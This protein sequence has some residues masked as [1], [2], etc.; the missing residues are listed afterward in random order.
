MSIF[1]IV[2]F[3]TNPYYFP[4]SDKS[5]PSL[6]LPLPHIQISFQNRI[7]K[8]KKTRSVKRKSIRKLKNKKILLFFTTLKINLQI[9]FWLAVED[10]LPILLP[11]F[12]FFFSYHNKKEFKKKRLY[13]QFWKKLVIYL[14]TDHASSKKKFEKQKV[15]LAKIVLRKICL[16]YFQTQFHKSI[17]SSFCFSLHQ[18]LSPPSLMT[19]NK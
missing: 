8:Y 7:I 3:L 17:T 16:L 13:S 18:F 10:L 12:A 15:S 19:T 1:K 5:L 9:F 2:K 11:L 4:L 14:Y 6:L